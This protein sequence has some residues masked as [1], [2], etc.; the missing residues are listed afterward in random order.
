MKFPHVAI[1]MYGLFLL[2]LPAWKPFEK[3]TQERFLIMAENKLSEP[4]INQENIDVARK[5]I[6]RANSIGE[7]RLY[8]SNISNFVILITGFALIT[9]AVILDRRLRKTKRPNQS[10]HGSGPQ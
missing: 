1:C 2:F 10:L 8:H 5:L 9:F 6:R 4:P 7:L 3:I